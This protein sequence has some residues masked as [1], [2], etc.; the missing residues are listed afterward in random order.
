MGKKKS[1][2]GKKKLLSFLDASRQNQVEIFMNG[3]GVT[4]EMV[5]NRLEKFD[6]KA[7]SP[8]NLQEVLSLYPSAE[9]ISSGVLRK[10]VPEEEGPD[11]TKV[12]AQLAKADGF[13]RGILGIKFFKQK[14]QCCMN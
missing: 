1:E 5:K 10:E 11:G 12:K 7:L 6:E 13:L 8:E 9:E 3:R 14:S 4:L 2:G